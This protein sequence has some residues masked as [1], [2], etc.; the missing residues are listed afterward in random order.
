M[1]LYTPIFKNALGWTKVGKPPQTL[2]PKK[3]ASNPFS[4]K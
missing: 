4:G 1:H 3:S 2:T